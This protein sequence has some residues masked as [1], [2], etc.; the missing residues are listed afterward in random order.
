[1]WAWCVN[2]TLGECPPFLITPHSEGRDP[3]SEPPGAS[4]MNC[5]MATPA[6]ALRPGRPAGCCFPSSVPLHG[7]KRCQFSYDAL[8]GMAWHGMAW[9]AHGVDGNIIHEAY[10]T[11]Y[12]LITPI[13]RGATP[14][15]SPPVLP[16]EMHDGKPC[17][18]TSPWAAGRLLHPLKRSPARRQA[19]FVSNV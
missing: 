1:M 16:I 18:C 15:L 9:H 6:N 10:T 13:P 19:L 3:S 4:Q 17:Q 12:L 8:H 2:G 5:M 14:P 11:A 7:G